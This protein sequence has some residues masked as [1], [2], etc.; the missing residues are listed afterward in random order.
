MVVNM[1]A[2]VYMQCTFMHVSL[3]AA[4][5]ALHPPVVAKVVNL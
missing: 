4:S 1:H 5:Q 3:A 2:C